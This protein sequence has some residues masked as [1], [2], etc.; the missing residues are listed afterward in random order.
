VVRLSYERN[1]EGYWEGKVPAEANSGSSLQY[2]H[3][4]PGPNARLRGLHIRTKISM[5][6]S[7][8]RVPAFNQWRPI[9]TPAMP[10]TVATKQ[11][12]TVNDPS[13]S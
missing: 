3:Y 13:I 12:L 1:V 5:P 7:I 8:Q 4:L 2:T 6:K 10:V 9:A 11:Q